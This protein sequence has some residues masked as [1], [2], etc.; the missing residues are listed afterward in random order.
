MFRAWP[1][2]GATYLTPMTLTDYI[3]EDLKHR[4]LTEEFSL[5]S[6]T[7]ANLSDYYKVSAIASAQCSQKL[8]GERLSGEAWEWAYFD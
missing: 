7:L 8:G 1:L 3:E 2:K 5:T 6:L 4:I